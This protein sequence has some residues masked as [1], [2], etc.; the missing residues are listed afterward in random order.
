MHGA[1]YLGFITT[2]K[3]VV[4]LKSNNFVDRYIKLVE[5]LEFIVGFH[6]RMSIVRK[7][8]SSYKLADI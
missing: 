3:W 8:S 1:Y 4:N 5:K 6:L 2:Y 7:E